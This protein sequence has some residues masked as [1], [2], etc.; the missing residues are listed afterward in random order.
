M[1]VS[2]QKTVNQSERQENLTF[3]SEEQQQEPSTDITL[4]KS[5]MAWKEKLW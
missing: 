3:V 4:I 5:E 1:R 2:Y